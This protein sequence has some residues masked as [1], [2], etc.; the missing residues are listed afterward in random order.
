MWRASDPLRHTDWWDYPPNVTFISFSHL[1]LS[2]WLSG[3]LV[4]GIKSP[5]L[6]LKQLFSEILN[7]LVTSLRTVILSVLTTKNHIHFNLVFLNY[8]SV[9]WEHLVWHTAYEGNPDVARSWKSLTLI[10]S[11]MVHFH[12]VSPEG[13]I[14]RTGICHHGAFTEVAGIKI[15]GRLQAN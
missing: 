8:N 15:S 9:F 3:L 10:H 6:S 7:Y 4:K 1:F 14:Q 5:Q 12:F 11:I 2:V 13:A